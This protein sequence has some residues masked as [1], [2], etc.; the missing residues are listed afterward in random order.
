MAASYR[1]EVKT[2]R[3][4]FSLGLVA[5][6]SP[7]IGFRVT[8]QKSVSIIVGLAMLLLPFAELSGDHRGRTRVARDSQ[9]ERRLER[10]RR[11]RR[12]DGGRN[13]G[14]LSSICS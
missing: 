13:V 6:K 10:T 1:N 11:G 8:G 12:H 2:A 5:K 3:V 4:A 9:L 14:W 7:L